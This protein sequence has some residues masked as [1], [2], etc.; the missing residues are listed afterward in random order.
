MG[1]ATTSWT[2]GSTESR[3]DYCAMVPLDLRAGGPRTL[4]LMDEHRCPVPWNRRTAINLNDFVQLIQLLSRCTCA[5][6]DR[7]AFPFRL[8]HGM[9]RRACQ[10]SYGLWTMKLPVLTTS[11]NQDILTRDTLKLRPDPWANSE[12]TPLNVLLCQ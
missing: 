4:I 6:I 1:S 8:R 7:I 11:L 12:F 3:A 10:A 2:T 9:G 5:W